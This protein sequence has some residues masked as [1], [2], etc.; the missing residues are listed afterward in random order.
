MVEVEPLNL[1]AKEETFGPLFA[2]IKAENNDEILKIANKTNYGLG[3]VVVSNEKKEI[4]Q[5]TS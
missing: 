4:E 5:F 1:L 3:A 2:L